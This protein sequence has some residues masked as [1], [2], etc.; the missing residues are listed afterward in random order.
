MYDI[1]FS[2]IRH[3]CTLRHDLYSCLQMLKDKFVIAL[4]TSGSDE[5]G[6]QVLKI[7]DPDHEIINKNLVISSAGQGI[8]CDKNLSHFWSTLPSNDLDST[9]CVIY[10]AELDEWTCEDHKYIW[11]I[12]PFDYW[13]QKDFSNNKYKPFW[14]TCSKIIRFT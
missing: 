14:D 3:Y 13:N 6:E 10:D 8:F 11:S 12:D 5:F 4:Y 1:D 7:I 2:T 9:V